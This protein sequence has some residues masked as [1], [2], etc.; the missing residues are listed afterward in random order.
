MPTQPE[1]EG[2]G[3]RSPRRAAAMATEDPMLRAAQDLKDIEQ[4]VADYDGK[5]DG[6]L[7]EMQ[8]DMGRLRVDVEAIDARIADKVQ[9]EVNRALAGRGCTSSAASSSTAPSA[10]PPQRLVGE[11]GVWCH[12]FSGFEDGRRLGRPRRRISRSLRR[13]S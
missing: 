1:E 2:R 8:E 3:S 5:V 9:L 4:H 7:Q 12:G 13:R 10:R 6:A 11:G